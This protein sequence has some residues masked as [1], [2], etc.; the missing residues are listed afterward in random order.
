[1]CFAGRVAHLNVKMNLMQ[2]KGIIK[3]HANYFEYDFIPLIFPNFSFSHSSIDLNIFNAFNAIRFDM[4][5]QR[6]K[7]RIFFRLFFMHSFMVRREKNDNNE[8][9]K[10]KIAHNITTYASDSYERESESRQKRREM[11][12]FLFRNGND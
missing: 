11:L 4:T 10:K 12:T 6:I 7:R 2:R 1:M 3:L 8:R 5:N 9:E